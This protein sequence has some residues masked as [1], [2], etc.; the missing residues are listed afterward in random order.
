[1]FHK[2]Q[3]IKQKK[4]KNLKKNN[5]FFEILLKAVIF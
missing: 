5:S 1:L 3:R 4:L 2:N